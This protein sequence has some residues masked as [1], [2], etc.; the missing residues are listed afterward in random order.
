MAVIISSASS[1][2]VM[3]PLTKEKVC[4]N[5]A[6]VRGCYWLV[7]SSNWIVATSTPTLNRCIVGPAFFFCM[8]LINPHIFSSSLQCFFFCN[9]S[10]CDRVAIGVRVAKM[11]NS[12]KSRMSLL[13]PHASAAPPATAAAATT[14]VNRTK[15]KHRCNF[16]RKKKPKT[17]MNQPNAILASTATSKER[18]ANNGCTRPTARAGAPTTI[19]WRVLAWVKPRKRM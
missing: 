15:R 3:Y 14:A 8:A 6:G 18:R 13:V 1:I 7:G 5:N 19:R 4:I 11:P 2:Q 12:I 17:K 9:V 16:W 10:R